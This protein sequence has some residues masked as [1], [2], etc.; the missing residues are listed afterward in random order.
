MP[1][2]PLHSAH[3]GLGARFVDFGGWEMPV[4][5]QSVLAEHR[6]VRRKAGM[7]DVSHLG[8]FAIDGP[9]ATDLI[10]RLLCNDIT[11]IPSGRAQ[12]TMALNDVG[13]I[14]D[15]I[16][17]WRWAEDSYWVMPNGV[18]Q[19]RILARFADAAPGD[20]SVENRQDRTILLAVQG[21]EARSI[22]ENV[23]GTAPG[24]LRVAW[25]DYEGSP[26]WMAGTGYTGEAGAELAVPLEIGERLF[27][28][29]LAAG[30]T[31]C[32]LGARDT[33]R[34]EMGFPL[35]GQDLD[36]TTTPLEA[37][38]AWVVGWATEFVGKEAL[39][40][41]RVGELSKRLVAFVMGDRTIAR[42]GYPLRSGEASGTVTSGNY[43]PVLG[44]GIGMGYLAPAPLSDLASVET[45]VRGKWIGASVTDIPFIEK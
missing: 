1:R 2:S 26:V 39:E 35:W 21:P 44:V 36:E 30:A 38:L 14:I 19:D 7:F 18:N 33:L 29:L 24:R 27:A 12:Y 34:L 31:P 11:S 25:S 32:G 45:L 3:E 20:V 8:R 15:D 40:A 23:L 16:I 28:A 41:Q 17:V 13:G 43:S 5:Y 9:G 22:L 4:Q 10:Q 6:A 42:H 37:G